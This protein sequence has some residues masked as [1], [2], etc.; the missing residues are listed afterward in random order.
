MITDGKLWLQLFL[1]FVGLFIVTLILIP[2]FAFSM[3]WIVNHLL[4]SWYHFWLS[5]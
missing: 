5:R 3:E 1:L 4:A 2:P